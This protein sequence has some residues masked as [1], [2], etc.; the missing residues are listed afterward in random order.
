LLTVLGKMVSIVPRGV[1]ALGYAMYTPKDRYLY[2]KQ[3]VE[4]FVFLLPLLLED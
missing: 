4:F 2:S 1:G 3:E